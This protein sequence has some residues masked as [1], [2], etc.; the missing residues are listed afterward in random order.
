MTDKKYIR[1]RELPWNIVVL[2][3]DAAGH[4]YWN[5]YADNKKV[6]ETM[7]ELRFMYMKFQ[8]INMKREY[9]TKLILSF[10]INKADI[11]NSKTLDVNIYHII[12]EYLFRDRL[13]TFDPNWL[14]LTLKRYLYQWK[15]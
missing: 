7:E 10:W 5:E 8:E 14:R 11:Q 2:I 12:L 13:K 4:I 3:Y 9:E 6:N 1:A 15:R